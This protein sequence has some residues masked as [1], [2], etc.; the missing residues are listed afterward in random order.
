MPAGA[1]A[2]LTDRLGA[3]NHTLGVPQMPQRR[4]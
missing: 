4:P 3:G 1:A 2:R